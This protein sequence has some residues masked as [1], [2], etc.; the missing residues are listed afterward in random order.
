MDPT[1]GGAI[2]VRIIHN[3]PLMV[4]ART[5][6]RPPSAWS[7]FDV[8]VETEAIHKDVCD[9]LVVRRNLIV[10]PEEDRVDD[11]STGGGGREVEEE[12]G[13]RWG[14]G[15]PC[16]GGSRNMGGQ[17]CCVARDTER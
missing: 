9:T 12:R 15:I 1:V 16:V 11:E 17:P 8:V 5:P 2:G 10:R 6:V 14:C 7:Q 13:G 3:P 4:I